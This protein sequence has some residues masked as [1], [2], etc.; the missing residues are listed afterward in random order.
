MFYAPIL[1]RA[2]FHISSLC[3]TRF[4]IYTACMFKGL[5][6]KSHCQI[7]LSNT[8]EG[9]PKGWAILAA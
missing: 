8:N 5:I 1:L 9:Q 2:M 4:D 7:N 3:V 6:N